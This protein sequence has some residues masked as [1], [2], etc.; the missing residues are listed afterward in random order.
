ML[1]FKQKS[2]ILFQIVK[3]YQ[4]LAK[5]ILY[6]KKCEKFGQKENGWSHKLETLH[7]D[8]LGPVLKKTR[9]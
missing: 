4:N 6:K 2:W 8:N 7:E 1:I 9:K 3:N 5:N